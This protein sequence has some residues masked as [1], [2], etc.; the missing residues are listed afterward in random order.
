ML[1]QRWIKIFK[2]TNLHQKKINLYSPNHPGRQAD[3]LKQL[4]TSCPKSAVIDFSYRSSHSRNLQMK[5]FLHIP[6]E[7]NATPTRA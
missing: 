3:Q 7:E 5:H 1:H 6:F 2:Y 4:K